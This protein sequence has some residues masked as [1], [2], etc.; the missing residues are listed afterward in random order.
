MTLKFG[1]FLHSLICRL[2]R[3]IAASKRCRNYQPSFTLLEESETEVKLKTTRSLSSSSSTS[4]SSA[5][6]TPQHNPLQ[7]RSSTTSKR[8]GGSF[9]HNDEWDNFKKDEDFEVQDASTS[10]PPQGKNI[11]TKQRRTTTQR[12]SS[13]ESTDEA[14]GKGS[15][16]YLPPRNIPA[17]PEGSE[18]YC[19]MPKPKNTPLTRDDECKV[20]K[21]KNQP[22]GSLE[23]EEA[24]SPTNENYCFMPKPKN[25]PLTRDDECKVDKIKNQPNGSLE[26]EEASSPTNENYCFMPKPKNIPVTEAPSPTENYCFLPPPKPLSPD[27]TPSRMTITNERITSDRQSIKKKVTPIT[28]VKRLWE[29]EDKNEK[30]GDQE[31]EA[32]NYHFLPPPKPSSP[33]LDSNDE[34]NFLPPPSSAPRLRSQDQ[35]QQEQQTSISISDK[36]QNDK[37]TKQ[38]NRYGDESNIDSNNKDESYINFAPIQ[39]MKMIAKNNIKSPKAKTHSSNGDQTNDPNSYV[40]FKY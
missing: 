8:S 4:T 18:N 38:T 23:N 27:T 2:Q 36:L 13:N 25:T 16:S 15:Y 35:Q 7:Q 21:I 37:H 1:H 26:N 10:C 5:T 33:S 12:S 40:N 14:D 20:D 34:Y 29:H 9:I 17:T 31:D 28:P 22:N 11:L 39:Q 32:P 24:S 19:F 30:S 6:S 3:E